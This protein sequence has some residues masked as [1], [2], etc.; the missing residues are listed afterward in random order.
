MMSASPRG[1]H[2]MLVNH[3]CRAKA[4]I[5]ERICFSARG[6]MSYTARFLAAQCFPAFITAGTMAFADLYHFTCGFCLKP[7]RHPVRKR[8][9]DFPVMGS[10]SILFKAQDLQ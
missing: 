2:G 8:P 1:S 4:L 7:H 9:I 10:Q 5:L 6:E 3:P